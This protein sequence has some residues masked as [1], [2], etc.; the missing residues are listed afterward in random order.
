M[1]SKLLQ[2]SL[3]KAYGKEGNPGSPGWANSWPDLL[4]RAMGTEPP[5]ALPGPG[6]GAVGP[7]LVLLLTWLLC[8]LDLAG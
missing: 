1:V 4:H 7:S 5:P 2:N 6:L 8:S 3:D